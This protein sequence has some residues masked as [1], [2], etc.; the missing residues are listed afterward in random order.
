MRTKTIAIG[1]GS[2]VLGL[3]MGGLFT[4]SATAQGAPPTAHYQYKCITKAPH[5]IWSP[6]AL[7]M[8][9]AEGGQGWRLMENRTV[10]QVASADVYCFER[11]Y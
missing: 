7:N 5:R 9:N 2:A 11:R 3:L 6:E 8:L 1:I 10:D 4:S